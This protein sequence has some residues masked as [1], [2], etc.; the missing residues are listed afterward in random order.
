MAGLT[1]KV[2][3]LGE[4]RVGKTSLISRYVSNSFDDKEASTV[5]ANMYSSKAVPINDTNG[6]PGSVSEVNLALWDTAGQERFHAL[7]PMYYRNADGAI[8]VYDVTDA[9]TLRKVRTWA[10]ELYAVVGEGNIQ[11]V[12]CGNKMDTPASEQ[13]VAEGEGASVAAELGASHFFASAKTGQNVADV[14]SAMA[15]QI[16][17]SR[18]AAGRG[19]S[20]GNSGGG[21]GLTPARSR[22][23]RGLMVVTEDG[24]AFA[25]GRGS[26]NEGRIYGGVA[27]PRAHRYGTNGGGNRGQPITFNDEEDG[28]A[29]ANSGSNASGGCC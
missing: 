13:E 8:I 2:V 29:A 18:E 24:E 17:R 5:Q 12:L 16:L 15:T 23:R 6:A 26:P 9:D 7:A 21:G 28:V 3:L 11:L 14:F 1:F 25:P 19:V 10:K 27:P 22:P 4:G 20:V